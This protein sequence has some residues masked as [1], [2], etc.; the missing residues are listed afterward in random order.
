MFNTEYR[1]MSLM[2]VYRGRAI[3]KHNASYRDESVTGALPAA[4]CRSSFVTDHENLQ[5]D[6][7]K[8]PFNRYFFL[9]NHRTADHSCLPLRSFLGNYS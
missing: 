6:P 1:K 7:F 2:A 8:G 3:V 4:G 9:S 5:S